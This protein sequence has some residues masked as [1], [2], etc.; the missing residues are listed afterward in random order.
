MKD[1]GLSPSLM[2]MINWSKKASCPASGWGW[3]AVRASSG[4]IVSPTDAAM[5]LSALDPP[6]LDRGEKVADNEASLLPAR[7]SRLCNKTAAIE[8]WT[9][10]RGSRRSFDILERGML[11]YINIRPV[12]S[13]GSGHSV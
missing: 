8:L 1:C 9:V 6:S 2:L 5:M 13:I 10:S 11:I 12:A 3:P 7:G 4:I